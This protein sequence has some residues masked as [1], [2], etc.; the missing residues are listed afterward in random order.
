MRN[1]EPMGRNQELMA[2]VLELAA[3]NPELAGRVPALFVKNQRAWT[4]LPGG[5]AVARLL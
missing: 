5:V 2:W 4:G 1:Q 3:R